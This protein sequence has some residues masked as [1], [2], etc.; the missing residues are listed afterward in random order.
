MINK[1]ITHSG[2]FHADEVMAIAILTLDKQNIVIERKEIVTEQELNDSEIFVLDIGGQYN[3][4]LSNYDHHQ[5][6]TLDATCIM[7]AN[8]RLSED[9]YNHLRPLLTKISDIDRG[10]SQSNKFDFNQII[11]GYN[12]FNVNNTP[13]NVRFQTA[14]NFA[15]EFLQCQRSIFVANKVGKDKFAKLETFGVVVI[16]HEKEILNWREYAEERGIQFLVCPNREEGKYSIITVD[17]TKWPIPP[18]SN[19]VFRHNS[20]FMAVYPSFEI[21]L[22]DAQELNIAYYI[23]SHLKNMP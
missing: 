7:I 15:R 6:S 14:V 10:I 23:K 18:N 3:E 21:A 4:N 16:S 19:Q 13:D 1:I 22:K 9:F 11:T 8:G 2:K 12:W 20:G 5:D 17:S